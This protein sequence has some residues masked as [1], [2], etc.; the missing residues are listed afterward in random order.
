MNT[1]TKA[2]HS[3]IEKDVKEQLEIELP[4]IIMKNIRILQ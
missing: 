1:K 4:K 3:R 2:I